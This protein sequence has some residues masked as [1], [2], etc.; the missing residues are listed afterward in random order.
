MLFANN[1][2]MKKPKKIVVALFGA[3]IGVINGFF[4]GGGGMIVVPLLNKLFGLEQKK[5]QATALFVILPI[6]VASAILYLCFNSIDFVAGWPVIAGVVAGGV[7][8]ATLL[9]KL[10]NKWV[11]GIFVLFMFVGGVS[12]LLR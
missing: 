6:S 5:A 11:K 3:L 2:H 10:N 7:V 8:G 4:G 12:M 9:N 1:K